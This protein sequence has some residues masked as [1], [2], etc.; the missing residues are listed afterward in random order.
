MLFEEC[1]FYHVSIINE[2][3][4]R[5]AIFYGRFETKFNSNVFFARSS[6]RHFLEHDTNL[7]GKG[8]I[9]TWLRW[10]WCLE[11]LTFEVF[12]GRENLR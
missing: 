10:W 11:A 5:S 4:K 12:V 8:Y 2:L 1:I 3:I 7:V 6:F 9:R